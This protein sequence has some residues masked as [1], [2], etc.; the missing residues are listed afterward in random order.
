MV[1]NVVLVSGIQQSDSDIHIYSV[2][3]SRFLLVILYIIV[4]VCHSET[5]DLSLFIMFPI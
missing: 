3:Y 1:Y 2:L 4:Y 5:P